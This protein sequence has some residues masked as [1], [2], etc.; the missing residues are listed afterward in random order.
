M[1][2]NTFSFFCFACLAICITLV[3]CAT[4]PE[5]EQPAQGAPVQDQSPVVQAYAIDQPEIG[6]VEVLGSDLQGRVVL[7]ETSVGKSIYLSNYSDKVVLVNYWSSW[8]TGCWQL[9]LKMQKLQIEYGQLGLVVVHV[10]YG[11]T[12][13]TVQNYLGTRTVAPNMILLTDH[14]GQA[15]EAQGVFSLPAAV[16]Y[17]KTGR[18]IGRYVNGFSAN[19][20]REKLNGLLQ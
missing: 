12:S 6:A 3:S 8:C 19:D 15:S 11:E 13:R 17:D 4:A 16:L 7:G 14:S 5:I 20:L 10:N 2:R 1:T 18:E 9:G